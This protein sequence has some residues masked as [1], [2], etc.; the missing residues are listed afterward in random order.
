MT[1]MYKGDR[2]DKNK[3]RGMLQERFPPEEGLSTRAVKRAGLYCPLKL[4][5]EDMHTTAE[6]LIRI[7]GFKAY[8]DVNYKDNSE[9]AL[10]AEIRKYQPKGSINVH[11]L[12][13]DK[14]AKGLACRLAGFWRKKTGK[15]SAGHALRYLGFKTM[16]EQKTREAVLQELREYW[17]LQQVEAAYLQERELKGISELK[18]GKKQLWH[19][20]E[21]EGT[22]KTINGLYDGFPDLYTMVRAKQ[23]PV[24]MADKRLLKK[25]LEDR[26]MQGSPVDSNDWRLRSRVM[27]LATHDITGKGESFT[28]IISRIT[29]IDK[30]DIH[31][32]AKNIWLIGRLGNLYTQWLL[33][34][35]TAF[36][37]PDNVYQNGFAKAFNAPYSRVLCEKRIESDGNIFFPDILLLGK[38]N[39]VVEIKTCQ[40]AQTVDDIA[41]KYTSSSIRLAQTGYE[42]HKKTAILHMPS[43]ASNSKRCM[44]ED[45]GYTVIDAEKFRYYLERFLQQAEKGMLGRHLEL[46]APL[47]SSTSV[48]LTFYD[49]VIYRPALLIRNSRR[50]EVQFMRETLE[51]I[52]SAPLNTF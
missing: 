41:G 13:T 12:F 32:T 16:R 39:T 42:I 14:N 31:P 50:A 38:R 21:R 28:Q 3:M 37:N 30:S 34:W 22:Q 51:D 2:L 6:N 25:Q 52:A 27:S 1:V 48:F 47:I 9:T 29:G 45:D 7:T 17:P 20:L 46:V 19:A 4:L 18:K 36:E 15:L 24:G 44:L 33:T 10:A 11:N 5:A 40:R 49:D 35:T 8:R 26:I 23:S 43:T